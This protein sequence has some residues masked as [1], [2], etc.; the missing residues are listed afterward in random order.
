MSFTITLSKNCLIH[1]AIYSKIYH[2]SEKLNATALD[3]V[4]KY[5]FS[6]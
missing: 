4:K 2:L 5:F 6:I 3:L 1:Y